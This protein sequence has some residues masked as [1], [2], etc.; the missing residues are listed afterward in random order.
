L[1]EPRGTAR[2]ASPPAPPLADTEVE[3]KLRADGATFEKLLRAQQREQIPIN[4]NQIDENLLWFSN[5]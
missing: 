2:L 1:T 3:L 5:R 4:L